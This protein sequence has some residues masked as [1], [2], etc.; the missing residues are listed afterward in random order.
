M[1]A[2]NLRRRTT[3]YFQ[4]ERGRVILAA[5]HLG[6]GVPPVPAKSKNPLLWIL[7]AVGSLPIFC[8][9]GLFIL[10]SIMQANM[11]P[12]ELAAMRARTNPERANLHLDY[13]PKF[14][15]RG[16]E[17]WVK[18]MRDR[19]FDTAFRAKTA[20]VGIGRSSCPWLIKELDSGK[21]DS[22]LVLDALQQIGTDGREYAGEI[23]R[24]MN[25]LSPNEPA[26]KKYAIV[27]EAMRGAPAKATAIRKPA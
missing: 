9:G 3:K 17:S 12:E 18:D 11:T 5:F 16:I 24:R 15:G 13:S 2:K 8:C 7:L 26:R 23:E 1:L 22:G 10:G 27:I 25:S 14:Q 6:F 20:L 21:S 19:D 4:A